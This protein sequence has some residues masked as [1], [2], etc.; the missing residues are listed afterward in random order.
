MWIWVPPNRCKWMMLS[1]SCLVVACY[2][3]AFY[4]AVR[5]PCFVI[6]L[7]SFDFSIRASASPPFAELDCDMVGVKSSLPA[8]CPTTCWANM[9][10]ERYAAQNTPP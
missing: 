9:G 2:L 3:R 6:R 7:T 5:V 8:D 10:G 4:S 1:F